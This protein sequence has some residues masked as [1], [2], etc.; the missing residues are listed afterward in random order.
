ML[1]QGGG[2]VIRNCSAKV[3]RELSDMGAPPREERMSKGSASIILF[4]ILAH[5]TSVLHYSLGLSIHRII[6]SLLLVLS[7]LGVLVLSI[8]SI[9]GFVIPGETHSLVCLG[10]FFFQKKKKKLARS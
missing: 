4:M 3:R 9:S 8:H 7:I 1:N 6:S 2:I 5:F 10:R